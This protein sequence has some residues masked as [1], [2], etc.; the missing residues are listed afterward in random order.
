MRPSPIH[1]VQL[2]ERLE[3]VVRPV[4]ARLV[5]PVARQL[6]LHGREHLVAQQLCRHAA[7][8]PDLRPGPAGRGGVV[9][10][11]HSR[12]SVARPAMVAEVGGYLRGTLTQLLAS[13]NTSNTTVA[14]SAEHLSQCAGA[15]AAYLSE[16]D[17][18]DGS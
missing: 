7:A 15:L 6:A 12:V 4:R 10:T 3:G 14:L 2:G 13:A 11:Q 8:R 17:R 18:F 5:A 9:A 16:N 1:A